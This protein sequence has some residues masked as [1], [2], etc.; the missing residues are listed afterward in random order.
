MDSLGPGK[1]FGYDKNW[2]RVNFEFK[3]YDAKP[4]M[5]SPLRLE[6]QSLVQNLCSF[7]YPMVEKYDSIHRSV[8]LVKTLV[9]LQKQCKYIMFTGLEDENA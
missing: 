1:W 3:A 5:P 7:F 4:T 8:Y 6:F 9:T 2:F